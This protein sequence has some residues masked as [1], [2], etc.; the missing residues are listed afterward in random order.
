[1]PVLAPVA[2]LS[3]Y[4]TVA[5]AGAQTPNKQTSA[6]K[7]G[8]LRKSNFGLFVFIKHQ[9]VDAH[10]PKP[11]AVVLFFVISTLKYRLFQLNTPFCY[12]QQQICLPHYYAFY[13]AVKG[14]FT[15]I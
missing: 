2:A 14:G 13:R 1:V 11:S 10:R 15:A 6:P 3:K 12:C 8:N 4:H 7:P 9:L 5:R